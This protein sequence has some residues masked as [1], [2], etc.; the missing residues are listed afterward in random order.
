MVDDALDRFRVGSTTAASSALRPTTEPPQPSKT[1]N[2]V[3]RNPPGLHHPLF[4]QAR[5]AGISLSLEQKVHWLS[6]QGHLADS[7]QGVVPADLLTVLATIH[8]QLG[9][10]AALLASKSGG[11]PPIPDLIHDELGCVIEVDEVQHFTT[12]RARTFDLYPET[13]R[14]GYSLT[15]YRGL[16]R[17]WNKRSDGAFAHNTASDFPN[18]GGRQAQ[19]AYNDAL[20]DLLAPTFTGHP[21]IRIAAPDRNMGKALAQLQRALEQL[22]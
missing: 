3:R 16:V 1:R 10:N 8:H 2:A 17:Q 13:V 21:V 12:A 19:R 5:A 18:P 4:A 6:G 11:P 20:R 7:L 15:D 9:G 22:G 14:L